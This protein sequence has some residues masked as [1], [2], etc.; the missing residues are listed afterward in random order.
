M[1]ATY[2]ERVQTVLTKEQYDL[3]TEV[4]REER[5]AVS[6]LVREAVEEVYFTKEARRRQR[7]ALAELITLNAPVDDWPEMEHEIVDG[8]TT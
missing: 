5:K 4:A 1:A 3:L 6:I 7:E 8:I 2:T